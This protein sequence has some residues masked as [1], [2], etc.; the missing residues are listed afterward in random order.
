MGKDRNL[1]PLR[2]G[3]AIV[4]LAMGVGCGGKGGPEPPD[5]PPEP[6]K[7]FVDTSEINILVDSTDIYEYGTNLFLVGITA[8]HQPVYAGDTVKFATED[9]DDWADH[10]TIDQ[11]DT[12]RMD[13][14]NEIRPW[15]TQTIVDPGGLA[16]DT[17]CIIGDPEHWYA[18]TVWEYHPGDNWAIYPIL[19]EPG[20]PD[21]LDTIIVTLWKRIWAEFDY[22]NYPLLD[23]SGFYYANRVFRGL[24]ADP[25]FDPGYA[26]D[27]FNHRI[28][29]R[30]DT[31]TDSGTLVRDF[32]PVL[33]T[34]YT[35]FVEGDSTNK[36]CRYL[37]TNYWTRRNLYTLYMV[38]TSYKYT[39]Q[40]DTDTVFIPIDTVFGTVWD[41][42]YPSKDR[43]MIIFAEA[44]KPYAKPV[45]GGVIAHET[46]HY[47]GFIKHEDAHGDS[48][49]MFPSPEN[50]VDRFCAYCVRRFRR[51]RDR[52]PQIFYIG[53][54]QA[55]KE[56]VSW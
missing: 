46:G 21:T 27:S 25:F 39:M 50:S 1:K 13:N 2:R 17:F 14:R 9:I 6:P 38:T 30:Y 48:C 35:K 40:V 31:R 47:I 44:L 20:F 53:P 15:V 56:D 22:Y 19:I 4:A 32:N 7:E 51:E 3:L 26:A 43:V 41:W 29:I 37:V 28:Y 49:L 36:I 24:P 23:D 55:K 12:A 42:N 52:G 45:T 33:D 10:D 5:L 34:I 8:S 11:N 54:R 16:I 18:D